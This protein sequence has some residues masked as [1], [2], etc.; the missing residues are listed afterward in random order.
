MAEFAVAAVYSHR[1]TLHKKPKIIGA[2][3]FET[4]PTRCHAR[5]VVFQ[6]RCV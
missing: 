6:V 4:I 5:I 3:V 1:S 2:N